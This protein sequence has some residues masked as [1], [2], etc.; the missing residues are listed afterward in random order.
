MAV[1]YPIAAVHGSAFVHRRAAPS[2]RSLRGLDWLNFFLADV[3]TGVGPFVAVYLAVNHWNP[4]QVGIA[5]TIGGIAGVL[6]QVPAGAIVD[7]TRQKRLL[8]AAAITLVA[9]AALLLALDPVFPIVVAAQIL[10]GAVSA[11]LGPTV[12][13][14]TLGLVGSADF[15]RRL[16]RN[17]AFNSAGNVAAALLIGGIGYGLSNQ[18]IFFAVPILAIPCFVALLA[19]APGEIDYARA[20]GAHDAGDG[21][22]V[23]SIRALLAN[24]RILRFAVCAV[25]FHFANAAMLPQLGEMLAHGRA[26]QSAPFMSACIIVTQTI[27]A[28]TATRIGRMAAQWGRRPLLLAGFGVLPI[29]GMLYT[30]TSSVPLLIGIQVL[31]GLANAIFGVVS[32]LV[33]AD[34]TRGTGR[35]NITQGT[36]AASVGIGASFS[37]TLAGY[38]VQRAG[39]SV[40]FLCLAAIAAFASILL[41]TLVPETGWK[42]TTAARP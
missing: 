1:S 40:S 7:G 11:A 30:V 22:A 3:Q 6:A 4:E 24:R 20:R 42:M 25:L 21:R 31:D 2:Q 27:I 41:F 9:A 16:G 8:I 14:M 13:A 39:Y 15:D 32:I 17:H 36:L 37:T 35:F 19:I 33:I 34:L 28:L 12:T 5:L 10:L 29:R 23:V 38:L 26:R 18:A